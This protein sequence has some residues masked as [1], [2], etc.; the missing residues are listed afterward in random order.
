MVSLGYVWHELR[1][2]WSRTLVTALGLAAGVGLVMGIVGVS[3][4]LSNAQSQALSPLSSVGTDIVVERTV[5][6]ADTSSTSSTT[7]TTVPGG[8]FA[9]RGDGGGGFFAGGLNTSANASDRTA[10][11]GNNSSILTDLSKLGPPGTKYSND[12]FVNGTLITFP[13]KAVADVAKLKDVTAAVPA[14]SLQA[15]HETGTVPTI[16]DTVTTGGQT[17][18]QAVR[19]PPLTAA[20]QASVRACLEASGAFTPPAGGTGGS[21]G[22]VRVFGGGGGGGAFGAAFT[23]CLPASYQQYE[24]QVVVPQQTITRVLNPPTTNTQTTGY[25]V[26]GV[27]PSNSSSGLITKAQLV[28]GTW[29][30]STPAHEILVSTAYASSN[31]IK[32]GQTWTI[33]KTAYKVVGLVNPTLTGDVSDIYFD[34]TTMQAASSQPARINEVL[35]KVAKSTDVNA[36]AAEIKKELPGATILTSKQLAGQVNGSL[37][38]AKKL[39]S[40][41]GVALGIIILIAALLIAALLTLSS[42]AKRVREIGTLRAIGWSRGRVVNQVLAEMLGI[43]VVGAAIGVCVGL[44]VCA[45]VDAFGPTLSYSVAG[46]VVGAS[47][48]SGLVH[49]AATAAAATKDIHLRTSISVLTVVVAAAIAILGALLAGLAGAWRAARLSP[50]SALRDLG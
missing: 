14:L 29:F 19:P 6:A 43:G 44:L 11:A 36:V 31:S 27:D 34:I 46:A 33:N 15:L 9:G 7:T 16:T 32:V 21:G 37:A 23:K 2:R 4:G 17:I 10:L 50:T 45:A 26:A 40:D 12:F 38:N 35:V 30:T 3:N 25:T 48:A 49:S 47:S 18:T 13:Q 20:Q 42:I 39:A 22:G 28:S 1:R 8:G 41:L 5:G 24:A